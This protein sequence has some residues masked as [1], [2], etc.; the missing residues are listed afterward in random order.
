MARKTAKQETS[1]GTCSF[2]GTAF[3]KGEMTKHLKN[4]QARR[5]ASEKGQPQRLLHISVEGAYRPSYWMHLEIPAAVTLADL[6][7]FLRAIWLECCGHL[8]EFTIKDTSYSS[9]GEGDWGFPP[10]EEEEVGVNGASSFAPPT[11]QTLADELTKAVS[12]ELGAD[13]KEVQISRI[14][15]KL[16]EMLGQQL[17]PGAPSLSSPEYQPFINHLATSLQQGTLAEEMEEEEEIEGAEGEMDI[18]LDEVLKV[19]DTFSYIYDFGSS[20]H[21]SF[22]VLAEREG[23]VPIHLVGEE[24]EEEEGDEND[25]L[26]IIIMA[27]NEPPDLRCQVCGQPATHVLP[28]SEYNTLE[29]AGLCETHAQEHEYADELLPV[30]N[31]PRV[32]VCGYTGDTEGEWEEE[33]EE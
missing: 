14:E 16:K 3:A 6:D 1:L 7:N 12:A 27:R 13:L 9:M 4:C 2:C 22:K 33:E 8:S 23:A 29:E 31:S 26:E 15:E 32:G 18:E 10:F 20:T 11:S 24:D 30:V 21:L 5:T 17:P 19:G 28:E 25:N